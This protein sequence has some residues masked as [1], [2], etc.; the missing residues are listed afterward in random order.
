[1]MFVFGY[2]IPLVEIVLIL[3]VITAIILLEAIVVLVLVLYYKKTEKVPKHV[4]LS[5]VIK[6]KFK[7]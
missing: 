4:T 2:E 3:G 1:M 5:G 6:S 7:K